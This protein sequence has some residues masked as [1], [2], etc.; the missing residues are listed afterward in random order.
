MFATLFPAVLAT[1]QLCNSAAVLS[2]TVRR[3]LFLWIRWARPRRTLALA[4]VRVAK[5]Q[6]VRK[7]YQHEKWPKTDTWGR[8]VGFSVFSDIL[9]IWPSQLMVLAPMANLLFSRLVF[10]NTLYSAKSG[11]KLLPLLFFL[12]A[13]SLPS[14]LSTFSFFFS[15]SFLSNLILLNFFLTFSF[16]SCSTRAEL[17]VSLSI[18]I[19]N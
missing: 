4:F 13:F 2:A 7:I 10:A 16:L 12:F 11:L 15:P 3:K 8:N 9:Q 5:C 19:T 6:N 17:M 14:S 1:L 18:V